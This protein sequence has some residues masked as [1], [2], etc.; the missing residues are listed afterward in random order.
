MISSGSMTAILALAL[1]LVLLV[2]GVLAAI[3]V[4]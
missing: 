3:L 4:A 1:A 2:A